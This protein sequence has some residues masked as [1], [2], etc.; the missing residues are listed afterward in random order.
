[1][2]MV[3]D[4]G[5]AHLAAWGLP[6]GSGTAWGLAVDT[7]DPN[8]VRFQYPAGVQ[9]RVAYIAPQ[10]VLELGTHAELIPRDAFV[11]RSFAAIEFPAFFEHSRT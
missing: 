6:V 1:M 8:I 4:F 9:Q 7:Q 10:V 2:G 11:I 5:V 3:G